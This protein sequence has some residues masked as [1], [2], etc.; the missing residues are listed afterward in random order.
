V[1]LT[2]NFPNVAGTQYIVDWLFNYSGSYLNNLT[3]T[4]TKGTISLDG[5]N[6]GSN[7]FQ[8]GYANAAFDIELYWQP[9]YNQ[10]FTDGTT[11]TYTISDSKVNLSASMFD[12]LSQD[13]YYPYNQDPQYYSA[14]YWDCGSS[15]WLGGPKSETT[16][17]VPEPSSLMLLGSGFVGLG[18]VAR[19]RFL[20]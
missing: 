1:N 18:V 2:L 7:E 19:R 20:R 17:T 3:F 11:Q 15:G 8:A 10:P 6:L 14:V 13:P 16:P 9:D 4:P 12:V 5:T